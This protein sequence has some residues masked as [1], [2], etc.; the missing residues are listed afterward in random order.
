MRFSI[1]IRLA[2]L[3]LSLGIQP[4]A[5][6]TMDARAFVGLRDAASAARRRRAS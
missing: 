4:S 1:E 2:M 6:R 3:A 5:I